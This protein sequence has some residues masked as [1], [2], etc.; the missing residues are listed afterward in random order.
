[1]HRD[2]EFGSHPCAGCEEVSQCIKGG[3]KST[4]L[5]QAAVFEDWEGIVCHG[6]KDLF[7]AFAMMYPELCLEGA[8]HD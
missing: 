6:G 5:I 3:Q 4:M 1:M 7:H 2:N 8:D